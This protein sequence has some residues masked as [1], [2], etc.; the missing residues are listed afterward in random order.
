MKNIRFFLS[1][2][3][4]LLGL[5]SL[6]VRAESLNDKQVETLLSSGFSSTELQAQVKEKGYTGA[7]DAET[8]QR[9]KKAGADADLI[10]LL[11][12]KG[13]AVAVQPNTD[14]KTSTT[15]NFTNSIGMEMVWVEPLKCWVGKYETLQAEY[16]KVIGQ[17]PS[18]FKGQRRP[19]ETVS[20]NDAMAFCAKLTQVEAA[21]G[22][23][24]PGTHYTLPTDA[25]WDVFAGDAKS[26]DAVL[27]YY[28]KLEETA[29]AGSRGAN[30]FGLYDV[31]GNVEEWCA[32]WY[33]SA[34]YAKDGN[35]FKANGEDRIGAQ[36][37]VL[38]GGC[39]LP[40]SPSDVT[41]SDRGTC[42]PDEPSIPFIY[43]I[44]GF[45]VVLVHEPEDANIA[46]LLKS[47]TE[48]GTPATTDVT[49]F[50]NQG[51]AKMAK[52]DYD[53]A[54]SDYSAAIAL[55][56]KFVK[57]YIKRG[58]CKSEKEDF[59]GAVA[60]YNKA[61]EVDPKNSNAYMERGNTKYNY[62]DYDGAL[63]D[64]SNVIELDPKN[65][66]A[67]SYRGDASKKKQDY[68]K[69]I[70]DYSKAIELEPTNAEHYVNRGNVAFADY[71][72]AIADYTKAIELNPAYVIAFLNRGIAKY[73]RK[74]YE[75]AIADYSKSIELDP[76]DAHYYYYRGKAKLLKG[77]STGA[78]V[79]FR[80]AIELDP[81]E[82][83]AC[84]QAC[85]DEGN[86][87]NAKASEN[88][89]NHKN[90]KEDYDGA[91]AVFTMAI[92]LDPTD[93]T[94]YKSRNHARRMRTMAEY[95][96]R[97]PNGDFRDVNTMELDPDGEIADLT[98]IIELDPGNAS[99]YLQYRGNMKSENKRDYDGAI[100]DYTKSVELDPNRAF[101]YWNRGVDKSKKG[102]AA[103]AQADFAK[104]IELNPKLKNR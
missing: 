91:M 99:E 27:Y 24:P 87:K 77:D 18:H 90:P 96:K 40:G 63:A 56:P 74:D 31:L 82:T 14:S 68:T 84:A 69:A 13:E 7:V 46:Q 60:D 48:G 25:Q 57:A 75:S 67:Y 50:F 66:I 71:E 2:L 55:D 59:D 95:L 4:V 81:K 35:P 94:H 45:R 53:G 17:N 5:L 49:N 22:K 44:I 88:E 8:F 37:R 76:A 103:G 12:S 104:A 10:L 11:K 58:C 3:I 70:A 79:D 19:V 86:A 93:V 89:D 83:A 20:W 1:A 32:D 97:N 21:S 29:N 39:W 42:K 30:N 100:A 54:L 34:I 47:K 65:A 61:I 51:S 26:D 92:E 52:K 36:F 43:G 38:R 78:M 102:D 62:K 101:S 72:S 9:L 73:N 85:E 28:T 41:V 64:Y 23:L 80:K 33:T 16:E 15:P 98:K 6:S